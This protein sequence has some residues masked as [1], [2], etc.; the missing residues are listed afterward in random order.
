MTLA[1]KYW[2]TMLLT[3]CRFLSILLITSGSVFVF[4]GVYVNHW[5]YLGILSWP[6][7]IMWGV[8]NMKYIKAFVRDKGLELSKL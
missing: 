1:E 4:L 8:V 3:L 7:F 6:L 2:A 5:F